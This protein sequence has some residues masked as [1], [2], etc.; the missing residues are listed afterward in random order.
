MCIGLPR[1]G[2]VR[3]R[4][5]FLQGNLLRG[6]HTRPSRQL[7]EN[8]K[9][10]LGKEVV[11][12]GGERKWLLTCGITEFDVSD[13]EHWGS[14]ISVVVHISLITC[15]HFLA[16]R[17]SRSRKVYFATIVQ[18][19]LRISVNTAI[20]KIYK[21]PIYIEIVYLMHNMF[22]ILN[23]HHQV[24]YVAVLTTNMDPY[25]KVIFL[26]SLLNHLQPKI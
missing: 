5:E 19:Y 3:L 24:L 4:S 6:S 22:R 14:A 12:V 11:D 7:Q 25:C 26:S 15:F 18:F 16:T 17:L 23:G 9:W 10:F 2:E 8:N 21:W 1:L 13:I 20:V